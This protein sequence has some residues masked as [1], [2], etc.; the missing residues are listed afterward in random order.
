MTMEGFQ[1]IDLSV[2]NVPYTPC[3]QYWK[4]TFRNDLLSYFIETAAELAIMQIEL[5]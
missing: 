5:R 4:C 2:R 3:S 1:C